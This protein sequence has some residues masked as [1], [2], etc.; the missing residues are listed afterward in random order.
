MELSYFRA[1]QGTL[2]VESEAETKVLE[3]KRRLMRDLPSSVNYV[4]VAT[5]NGQRQ[6]FVVTS[7]DVPHKADVE[8]LPGETMN[9]GDVISFANRVT[10]EQETWIV[11]KLRVSNPIQRIGLAWLCNHKFRW[12]NGT[13]EIIERWGVLDSGV[14]S[15]TIA[16]D[17]S[18]PSTDVQFKVFLPLDEDTEKIYVDKRLAIGRGYDANG[19]KILKTYKVTNND[20]ESSS[21]GDMGHLLCLNIRSASDYME[22]VDS[23]DEMICDY[24]APD[25]EG[26]GEFAGLLSCSI[27]GSD[28]IRI[29]TTRRYTV[30]FYAANGTT[31]VTEGIVPQISVSPAIEGVNVVIDGASAAITVS[32]DDTL[33]GRALTITAADADGLYAPASIEAEVI[34]IG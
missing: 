2:D 11:V 33:I 25:E 8:A 26:G 1:I 3:A 34:G 5:R 21:Y 27:S 18:L 13:P 15:T 14:Y 30:T 23:Y 4:P 29:G 19:R 31:P 7:S 9:V 20:A 24:I 16:A 22:T 17:Y 12:Q 6:S 28:A 32:R 10:G